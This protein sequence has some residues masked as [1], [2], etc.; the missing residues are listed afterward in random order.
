MKKWISALSLLFFAQTLLANNILVQNV[1]TTGNNP[2]NKTIQVQFDLSW[3]NSWRDS[4]N[5]DAAWVF[6]KFKD[7]NGFWQH[8]RLNTAGFANGNGTNNIV[9]VTSDNVGCWVYRSALGSGTFN[10]TNMQLQWNYG[11]SGVNDVTG[12]EVRVF[13]VEMVYVPEGDFNCAI[14]F[15]GASLIAPGNNFPV[16]NSRLTP[17]LIYSPGSNIAVR[18]K[19]DA[20]IDTDNDGNIDNTTYPIGYYSF[21]GFKYEL[22]E[23]QYADFLNTLTDPQINTLGIAGS[24]ITL[25]NGQYFSSAPNMACGKSNPDRLFAYADW[26]GLRPM[27]ILELNKLS[28]GPR[29]PIYI[30]YEFSTIVQGYPAGESG[31]GNYSPIFWDEVSL[32]NVGSFASNNTNRKSSG[33][34]YFG[35]MDVSGNAS[36]PVITLADFLFTNQNGDGQISSAGISDINIWVPTSV[37]FLDQSRERSYDRGQNR[38]FRYVR[39]AE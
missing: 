24:Q 15:Y 11:L 7:A 35:L 2:A 34:S 12:L 9:K 36:E 25:T 26:S 29:Q 10:S 37:L 16:V 32:I 33:A 1:T 8:A 17:T 21:Y 22:T 18:I 13:A 38:G 19:G 3:D 20:G 23:Q 14:S 39:S 31:A 30:D 5:W 28:Y 6:I 27:T 4:I